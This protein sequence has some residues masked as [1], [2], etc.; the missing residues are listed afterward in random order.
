MATPERD[1]VYEQLAHIIPDLPGLALGF[2]HDTINTRPGL[3]PARRELVIIGALLAIGSVD[4]QLRAHTRAAVT[5]GLT[6]E[7]IR[8]AVLQALPYVGFPRTINAALAL[9][10]LLDTTPNTT[11]DIQ[12]PRP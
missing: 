1:A 5:A 4:T 11:R 9:E 10:E 2:A 12:E 6:R 7:E 8:E 3:D